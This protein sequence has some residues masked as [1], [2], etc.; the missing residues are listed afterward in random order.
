MRFD[1][2]IELWDDEIVDGLLVERWDN[3][4]YE[5]DAMLAR[6]KR[7]VAGGATH[8]R[9]RDINGNTRGSWEIRT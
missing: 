9:L 7:D 4:A 8:G 6:I 5:L 1:C 3:I 2:K